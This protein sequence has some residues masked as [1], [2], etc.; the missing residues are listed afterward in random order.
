MRALAVFGAP[1]ADVHE[2]DFARESVAYQ[3]GAP[4]GRIDIL[5]RTHRTHLRRRLAGRLR[6]SFGEVDVET[7][8]CP[9]WVR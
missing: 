3:I 9:L 2:T 4:P 7:I 1:L 8:S 6:R 5:D